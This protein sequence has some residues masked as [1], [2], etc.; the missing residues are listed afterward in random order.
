MASIRIRGISAKVDD[1]DLPNKV[2]K[3][4]K[5]LDHSFRIII[6]GDH[7][8]V[9]GNILDHDVRKKIELILAR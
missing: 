4:R 8:S 6:E 9:E 3:L 1:R 2:K 7:I 5:L